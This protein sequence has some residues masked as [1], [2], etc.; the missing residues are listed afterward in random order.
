MK[1]ALIMCTWKR[2]HRL[3]TTLELLEKQSEKDFVFYIW[4][5]NIEEAD[6][7]DKIIKEF[8]PSFEV[9]V[10]HNSVNIGGL[11]RFHIARKLDTQYVIFFDDDQIFENDMVASMLSEAKPKSIMSNWGWIFNS[12]NEY[13]NRSRARAGDVADYCGTGGMICDASIF[14]QEDFFL[15]LPDKYMFVEDLWLS[16]YAS[17]KM[18]W[19]LYGIKTSFVQIP[20]KHALWKQIKSLKTEMFKWLQSH[21][22]WFDEKHIFSRMSREYSHW[23]DCSK[24]RYVYEYLEM[25]FKYRNIK[26]ILDIG[27]CT[28]MLDNV[29]LSGISY[30]GIEISPVRHGLLCEAYQD[31][32]FVMGNAVEKLPENNYDL[33]ICL[34]V[35]CHYPLDLAKK[36][37]E[38][39]INTKSKYLLATQFSKVSNIEIKTGEWYQINMCGG[40]FSM[41]NPEMAI[42][43]SDKKGKYRTKVMALWN[44]CKN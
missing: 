14:K 27:P 33:V 40:P 25:L 12:R 37:L 22:N 8:N 30:T 6:K 35:M 44:L 13:W 42:W 17:Y 38:N 26:S 41:H 1:V 24:P 34:D 5:N 9:E 23:M 31:C 10:H 15:E 43:D 4:N 36:M 19:S 2:V 20:D 11:G 28:W 29:D 32:S 18:G 39:I 21:Y 7:I 3:K 16:F